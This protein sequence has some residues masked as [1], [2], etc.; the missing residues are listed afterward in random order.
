M[1]QAIGLVVGVAIGVAGGVMFSKSLAPEQ[2]SIEE[3]LEMKE[4]ELTKAEGRIRS[5]VADGARD[6][7]RG[8]KDGVREIMYRIRSGEDVSLDDVFLTMKPWMR[9]MAPLFERMRQ[10]NEDEYADEMAGRWASEY[11]LTGAEKGRLR[12]WFREQSKKKANAFVDVVES[13]QS[14]FVDF[15]RAT[16]YDWRDAEGVEDLMEQ[17]LDGQEL[18]KFKDER[19]TERYESVQ[20]ESYR[21]LNRLD[22]ILELDSEQHAKAFG[23]MMR[24]SEDYR[25]GM[26]FD[27]MDA[28]TG[29]LDRQSRNAAIESILRLD[30]REQLETYRAEEKAEAERNMAKMGLSLP[31]DWEVL[32]GDQF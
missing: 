7:K 17:M 12:E 15:V 13:N 25:E 18:E 23:I 30:Q 29:K 6:R 26:N 24:G 22:E 14:G 32:E 3:R 11:D 2:G 5:L 8:V 21:N 31:R 27:G 9:E 4:R 16:E 28:G 20:D 1:K 19:L 10:V